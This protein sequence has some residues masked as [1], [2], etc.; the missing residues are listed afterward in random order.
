MIAFWGSVSGI[1]FWDQKSATTAL[2][3]Q[4]LILGAMELLKYVE[5]NHRNRIPM[6]LT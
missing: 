1:P 4:S 3:K 5:K 6:K 2:T